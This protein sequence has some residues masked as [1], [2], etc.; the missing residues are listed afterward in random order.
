LKLKI[1]VIG[2]KHGHIYDI[3]SKARKNPLTEIVA[4]SEDDE[5][6]RSFVE[7]KGIKITYT[8]F[9][10]ML[11]SIDCD[12]VAVGDAYGKRG[13][14]IIEALKR[15]KHVISDKP[16][17]TRISEIEQIAKIV[18]EKKLKI[19]C[20]LTLRDLPQFI[21]LRNLIKSGYLGEIFSIIF[22]GH[23]PLM[24]E[25]RPLWYF[26]PDMHGGTI[27][28]IGIHAIDYILWATE[29]EF[30]KINAARSWN[31]FAKKYPFFMDGG[32]MMLTMENGCGV[33]GDVS[34]F[35]PDSHGY[36]LPFYWRFTV[37]GTDGIA[38]TSAT[39]KN[40]IVAKAGKKEVSLLDLPKGNDGGYFNAFIN[41]IF[42][43]R[44]PEQLNTIDV[45]KASFITLLVQQAGD[46]NYREVNIDSVSLL[47]E[48]L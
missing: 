46:K 23:H 35:A 13:E 7:K 26:E 41:D 2:F 16:I 11:D 36:S 39:S 15:N 14:I 8:D 1:A 19:G 12:I 34:Y 22:T 32:Q 30:I 24:L 3:I 20:Q 33:L 18:F 6:T 10:K 47:K 29:M 9:I 25:E 4:A 45:I 43:R 21:G 28:D 40:I 31:A 37:Y 5:E 42:N 17:C 48:F 27:N 44:D 38:E